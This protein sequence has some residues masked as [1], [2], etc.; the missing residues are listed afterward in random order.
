VVLINDEWALVRAGQHPIGQ[1]LAL[2]QGF[3][4]DAVRQIVQAIGEPVEYLSNRIITDADRNAFRAWAGDQFRP[5]FMKLGWSAKPGE[6]DETKSMRNTVLNGIGYVARDPLVLRQAAELAQQ[7][8][9][10]PG[11]VDANVAG[12]ALN[13]AALEGDGKLYDEYVAQMKAAKSP[14][15]LSRYLEALTNFRQPELTR[16]T[17]EMA[18][19][20]EVRSQDMFEVLARAMFNPESRDVSWPFMKAHWG[21][22]EKKTAG[23]LGFGF[24]MFASSF[25]S[26]QDKKDVQDWFA[27][28]PD[29]G[30]SRTLRQGLERVDDCMRMKQLQGENLASWLKQ[31]GSAA[32]K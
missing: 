6:D 29:P 3:R 31:H 8:M 32:G 30:S 24:G 27:Q 20:P 12:T 7:Y 13:L 16:R 19:S 5:L 21:E 2:A 25:C 14:E 17:L 4:N 23:G 18:L 10:D 28:H 26:E 11:S 15:Q 22:I 9:K 1:F